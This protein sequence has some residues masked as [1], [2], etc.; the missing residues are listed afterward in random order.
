MDDVLACQRDPNSNMVTAVDTWNPG[1]AREPNQIDPG[2]IDMCPY[3][4][5]SVNGR[6]ICT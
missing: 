1:P 6:I 3:T 4:G 5:D 2:Q